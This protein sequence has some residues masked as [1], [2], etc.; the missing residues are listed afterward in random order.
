MQMNAD[1]YFI[2]G[3]FSFICWCAVARV[4]CPVNSTL[5][6][7]IFLIKMIKSGELGKAASHFHSL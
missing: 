2:C 5:I 7:P 6:T 1:F 4:V 3:L